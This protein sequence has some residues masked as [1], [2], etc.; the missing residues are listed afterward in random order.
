MGSL[1]LRPGPPAWALAVL[2][3]LVAAAL[4]LYRAAGPGFARTADDPVSPWWV[5]GPTLVLAVWVSWRAVT[6]SA[7]LDDE[8]LRC[9][10]LSSTFEVGWPDVEELEVV[11]R[12]GLVLVEIRFRTVRR[13][14]RLGAATRF[15]GE[16]AEAVLDVIRAHPVAGGLLAERES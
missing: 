5:V 12:P 7:T 3:P 6:Q 4:L 2:A 16:E 9:R 1:D 13:S 14:H 11:R 8:A 15:A 10:N